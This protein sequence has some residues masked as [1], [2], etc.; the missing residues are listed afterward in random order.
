VKRDSLL[1]GERQEW[2]SGCPF[3]GVLCRLVLGRDPNMSIGLSPLLPALGCERGPN[4][5]ASDAQSRASS[6]F[7]LFRVLYRCISLAKRCISPLIFPCEPA[8]DAQTSW[9]SKHPR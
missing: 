8:R 5:A 4:L 6:G 3:A 2:K 7:V 1:T 9:T